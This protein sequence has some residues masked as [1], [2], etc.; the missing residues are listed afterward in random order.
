MTQ[1]GDVIREDWLCATEV[2]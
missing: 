2:Q 1:F